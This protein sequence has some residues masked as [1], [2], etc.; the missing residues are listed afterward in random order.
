[1]SR[2]HRSIL[3]MD[4]LIRYK[5]GPPLGGIV[6]MRRHGAAERQVLWCGRHRASSAP[7]QPGFRLQQ[8][9]H[10]GGSTIALSP[11]I[12]T[13]FPNARTLA[14]P[15]LRPIAPVILLNAELDCFLPQY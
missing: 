4:L 6:R 13:P 8:E 2:R 3:W 15:N 10:N 7:E 9:L 12:A 11:A 1:M 14:V 5:G